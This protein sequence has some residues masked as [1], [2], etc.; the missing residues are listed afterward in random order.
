MFT[1][2]VYIKRRFK[3]VVLYVGRSTF[4]FTTTAEIKGLVR[5][6]WRI[7][8]TEAY[9]ARVRGEEIAPLLHGD[10]KACRKMSWLD[11]VFR[12]AARNGYKVH[13]NEYFVEL[14]LSKP[15]GEPLGRVG[16]IDERALSSCIKCFTHS[17]LIWRIVTPPWCCVC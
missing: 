11:P 16:E 5:K 10:E 3:K 17:Y 6:R 13:P 9:S 14:W 7:G 1:I 2:V 15:L 4:V 12:E 8:R